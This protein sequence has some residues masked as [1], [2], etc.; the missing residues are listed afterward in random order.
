MPIRPL[1]FAIIFLCTAAMLTPVASGDDSPFDVGN[2]AQ[3]FVDQVL[4]RDA[5]N[6]AFTMHPAEKHSQNP[7]IRADQPWEGWRLEIYGNVLFDNEEQI[8]KMWYLG[9]PSESYDHYVTCYATSKDGI[10]WEKPTIG[11]LP[12]KDGRKTNVVSNALLA[13]VMKDNNDPDPKRRYKMVC[14]INEPKPAGGPHTYTSPDGL[15]WTRLS[16]EPICRSS[17]VLTAYYDH[18]RKKYVALPKHSTKVGTQVRRCF[19]LSTS[20]DFLKWTEPYYILR[21]DLR[22]DAGS[23]ARIEEVRPILDQPDDPKLMRTEFYGVGVYQAESCTLG[24]PWV[25][26]VNNNA[27]YGNHEGPGELQLA[28]TRDLVNWERPF[29]TPCVPRGKVGEWDSGFFT[30]PSEAIRV[31]DEI[32]LYYGGANYTHGTPCLYRAEGTGRLTEFTGS[33]GLATWKLD[34]FVS[35]DGPAS[36]GVLTTVPIKFT[37]SRLEINARTHGKGMVIVELCDVHGRPLSDY[38]RPAPFQ[39][40]ELRADVGFSQETIASLAGE[41]IC[42]RFHLRDA[43]LFSFAFRE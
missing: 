18:V 39:G 31:G 33:I 35:A 10:T 20:D 15:N 8:Y 12:A 32:R 37:G 28:V 26:T 40:D 7:L 11:T 30:T 19:A 36:G 29:R 27:R 42:L 14:W 34:R 22:D 23:L 4:V 2:R 5:K 41:P 25:F 13:S 21:P 3:L 17:D 43:E 1:L 16:Q 24:F 38:S 9:M 6:V